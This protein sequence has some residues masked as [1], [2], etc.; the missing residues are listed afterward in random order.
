MLQSNLHFQLVENLLL[1]IYFYTLLYNHRCCIL[2]STLIYSQ[3]IYYLLLLKPNTKSNFFFFINAWYFSF[4]A[5]NYFLSLKVFLYNVRFFIHKYHLIHFRFKDSSY[6]LMSILMSCKLC[7][8]EIF[9]ML[10]I[11]EIF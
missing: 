3:P 8:Y 2:L 5:W 6:Y 9:Y 10:C 11:C 4:I 7:V 1:P